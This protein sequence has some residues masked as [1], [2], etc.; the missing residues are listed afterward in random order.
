MDDK[1]EAPYDN[2]EGALFFVYQILMGDA[3]PEYFLAY[4][5]RVD[6]SEVGPDATS[7]EELIAHVENSGYTIF[8][9]YLLYLAA[10]FFLMIIMLNIIIAIMGDTQAK[11]SELG[12]AVIY[13]NQLQ[14][15][16]SRFYQFDYQVALNDWQARHEGKG[17]Y[18]PYFVSSLVE[19]GNKIQK[20]ECNYPRYLTVAYNRS[21]EPESE[22]ETMVSL[23]E[24]T[25]KQFDLQQ[26]NFDM[27]HELMASVD[28]K[29]KLTED[30][31]SKY[32]GEG[33]PKKN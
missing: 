17:K 21:T 2:W 18:A 24:K 13:R 15:V 20:Y 27:L 23:Q 6:T 31:I 9:M 30:E 22:L 12:R 28:E 3:T 25:L 4:S 10:S 29:M 8:V 19:K 14:T 32:F 33:A 7:D 5:A 16:L 26:R 11:R 1:E